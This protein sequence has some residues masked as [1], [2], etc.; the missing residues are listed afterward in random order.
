M[1]LVADESVDFGI[2]SQLRRIGITVVSISEDC[3]GIKDTEVLKIAA[4]RQC[5]LITEDKDFG[6]LTYRLKLVNSGILLIRLSDMARK[7]RIKLVTAIVEKNFDKLNR[8]FSVLTKNGLRI[9]TAHT[10]M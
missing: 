2:I 5:L 6:E 9:K 8:N 3:P 4:D 7:E 1:T 10:Q